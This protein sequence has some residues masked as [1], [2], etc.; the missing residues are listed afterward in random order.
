MQDILSRMADIEERL[1]TIGSDM[2]REEKIYLE[3]RADR[4]RRGL[5]GDDAIRHYEEWM[6]R[7]KL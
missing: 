6:Q 1:N 2:K 4:L 7:E 5:T 3:E